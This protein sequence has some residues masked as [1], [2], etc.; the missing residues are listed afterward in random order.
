MIRNYERLRLVVLSLSK[1]RPEDFLE[2][3]NEGIVAT[4]NDELID[5]IK[6]W[7]EDNEVEYQVEENSYTGLA[8]FKIY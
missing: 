5:D 1:Y 4:M 7:L 2:I 6:L 3:R 8:V